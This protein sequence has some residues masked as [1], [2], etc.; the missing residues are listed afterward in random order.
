VDTLPVLRAYI[1]DELLDRRRP[2]GDDESLISSGLL[3]S[4]SLH[5]LIA[6]IEDTFGVTVENDDMRPDN[7]Q[8]L[9]AIKAFLDRKLEAK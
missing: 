4:L 7:F 2:I 6:F 8:S 5:E 1:A 3:D 9:N